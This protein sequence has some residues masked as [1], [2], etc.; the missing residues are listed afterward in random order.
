MMNDYE[1]IIID[2]NLEEIVRNI[3]W[4][5]FPVATILDKSIYF[6]KIAAK[7]LPKKYIKW[8]TTLNYIIGVPAQ[9]ED[10]NAYLIDR[11][12]RST[13]A[14][15]PAQLQHEKKVRPGHYKVYKFGDGFAMKRN[16]RIDEDDYKWIN[17]GGEANA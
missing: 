3:G 4:Y 12:A 16:E 17:Q 9:K 14:A 2:E 11:R 13:S 6:N 1:D 10:L 8:Y 7:L 5:R 15:L